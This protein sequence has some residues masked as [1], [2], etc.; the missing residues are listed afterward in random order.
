MI[1]SI[2][3]KALNNIPLTK[4]EAFAIAET[5]PLDIPYLF[6]SASLIRTKYK[7]NAIDLCAIINAKSGACS[8]DCSYCAQSYKN[9]TDIAVY[10][11][12]NK[13]SVY[14]SAKEA[15]KA[16]VKKF[17]IVISGRKASMDELK[18]IAVMIKGIKNMGINPCASLGLLDKDE[19]L[20]LKDNGLERYHHNLETSEKFFPKICKTHSYYDKLK[21]IEAAKSAGLSI[22]SGGIFGMGETWED[23]ID[24]AFAVKELEVDSVPI[25]FLVPIKGTPLASMSLLETLEALKIIS[26][27]RF[28]L[29]KKDIRICGGR[30]QVLKDFHSFVFMAGADSVM[31]GN[32]LTTTGRSYDDDLRLIKDLGL[33]IL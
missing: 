10:P 18:K 25:N 15:L 17:S 11:L 19:L 26:L 30:T 12:L 5:S 7:N 9:K 8:E 2:V 6:Y 3:D 33:N 1:N 27:Y 28:V 14:A 22:C 29:P 23:R 32:Y 13:D 21:T 4:A 31:T 24:M 16:G 20:F